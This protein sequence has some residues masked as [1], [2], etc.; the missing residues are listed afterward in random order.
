MTEWKQIDGYNGLYDVCENGDI[1]NKKGL[2]LKPHPDSKKRYNLIRLCKNG[3]MTTYLLHRIV[4]KA[5]IPNRGDLEQVNH[6]DGNKTNNCVTNLEW[7]SRSYNIKH[8]WETGLKQERGC[9]ISKKII[10]INIKTGEKKEFN[11]TADAN[12]FLFNKK[13]GNAISNCLNGRSKSSSG[14]YWRF[15]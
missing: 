14:Y 1:R 5:F 13:T 10:G 8:A 12:M 6:I 7:C 4:A 11:S 15:K 2:I 9:C 3:V